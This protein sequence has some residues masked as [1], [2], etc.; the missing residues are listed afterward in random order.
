ML[1]ADYRQ[2][3]KKTV[4]VLREHGETL[5]RHF[6]RRMFEH[7]PE[8]KHLFN[9][10]HQQSG[11]QQQALALA[12]LAYAEH[13]DDPSVLLPVLQ[14]IA[15]K[16]ASL[17]IRPEHYPIVGGHLL[18]SIREVLGAAATDDLI[19]AWAAAYG[20]LADLLIEAEQNLYRDAALAK[21]GWS[22]WRPFKVG[23][24]VQES[25]EITSFYLY[26]VDGA[27]VPDFVPGQFVSVRGRVGDG[28]IVQPRQYSL[29]D[30][31]NGDYLRL[32]IKR[33]TSQGDRPDGLISNW[34]HDTVAVGTIIELSPPFGDFRL[35]AGR[36]TPVVLISGGVG[37]TPMVAMLNHLVA[38]QPHRP[39]AFIHG[40]R[41][42][43]VHALS[44][45]VRR[46]AITHPKL[47]VTVFYEEV[48]AADRL[49][50]DYDLPGRVD[51]AAIRDQ[52]ILPDADYYICG[53]V[54]FMQA[55]L[56]ALQDLGVPQ[57]RIH[58]EVFGSHVLAAA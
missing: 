38:S 32:S 17:G 26:P 30:A 36:D 18:A 16:H 1:Q 15:H 22:G 35:H 13:I 53:P 40:A 51:L 4:P 23:N 9:L 5:T 48:D 27:S 8:L 2:R 21:G 12:I 47:S 46:V 52:A 31:P 57:D 3:V 10:G 43:R 14:R 19:D 28:S 25:D 41:H 45:H 58:Y 55:K 11:Q 33:E 49:G 20:Q 24:R 44:E 39:V 56:R 50:I 7:N 34:M 6:Y 54:P 29:S 37:L 42:R